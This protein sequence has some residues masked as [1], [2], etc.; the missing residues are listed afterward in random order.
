VCDVP[1]VPDV[2]DVPHVPGVK[3]ITIH[4][5]TKHYDKFIFKFFNLRPQLWNI[6]RQTVPVQLRMLD[7]GNIRRQNMGQW[8]SSPAGQ[9]FVDKTQQC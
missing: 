8:D 3:V 9:T 6:R 2:P 7:L 4:K 1:E 5:F